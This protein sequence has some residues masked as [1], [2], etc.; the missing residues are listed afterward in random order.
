MPSRD[1]AGRRIPVPWPRRL[2]APWIEPVLPLGGCY[3]PL[4]RSGHGLASQS[5][6]FAELA[7]VG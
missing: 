6:P 7:E 4:E 1:A 5:E 2:P 3:T